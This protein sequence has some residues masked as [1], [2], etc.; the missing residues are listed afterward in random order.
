[1]LGFDTDDVTRSAGQNL[2]RCDSDIRSS[3]KHNIAT[4]HILLKQ[5]AINV[6]LWVTKAVQ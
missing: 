2:G 3:I 6:R 1:M 4:S 5:Q